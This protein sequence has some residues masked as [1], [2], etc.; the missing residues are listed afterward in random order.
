MFSISE[1]LD[2]YV[3]AILL[4]WLYNG[5]FHFEHVSSI[6]LWKYHSHN[7]LEGEKAHS[8]C[9]TMHECIMCTHTYA[10]KNFH[11]HTDTS[12]WAFKANVLYVLII[13]EIS[14]SYTLSLHL[15][16]HFSLF[17]QH[18]DPSP[19]LSLWTSSALAL[20]RMFY[21]KWWGHL[22]LNLAYVLIF[23]SLFI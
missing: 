22:G 19:P 3:L 7:K 15:F 9:Y 2:L 5:N 14:L 10:G 13:S 18:G 4:L 21:S 12:L 17:F 23:K 16:L 1:I 8:H 6:A 20:D 11:K